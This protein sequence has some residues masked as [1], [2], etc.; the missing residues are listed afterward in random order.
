MK[1]T[2]KQC[3]GVGVIGVLAALA[4]LVTTE[5]ANAGQRHQSC[6]TAYNTQANPSYGFGPRVCVHPY[7]V[8]VGSGWPDSKTVIA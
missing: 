3:S 4:T 6:Q 2:A 7:D 1:T 5:P 8:V